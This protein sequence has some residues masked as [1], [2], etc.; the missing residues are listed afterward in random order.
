MRVY[1]VES[2]CTKLE[3]SH[4]YYTKFRVMYEVGTF[5]Q[6]SQEMSRGVGSFANG[7]WATS[8]VKFRLPTSFFWWL[9][10]GFHPVTAS[11]KSPGGLACVSLPI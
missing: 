1:Y 3:A 2:I 10:A 5:I 8:K 11:A 7:S 6:D 9:V 4:R